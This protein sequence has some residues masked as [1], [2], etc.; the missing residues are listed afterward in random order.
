M[1]KING[2]STETIVYTFVVI[3]NLHNAVTVLGAPLKHCHKLA[4]P[5]FSYSCRSIQHFS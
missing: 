2:L 3:R 1:P 4:P 5:Q